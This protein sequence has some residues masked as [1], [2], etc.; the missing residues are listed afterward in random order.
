[1]APR[2]RGANKR[3][4]NARLVAAGYAFRYPTFREGYGALLGA[5]AS[6][7]GAPPGGTAG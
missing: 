1:V 3:C 2:E 5:G 7:G 4:S 6:G